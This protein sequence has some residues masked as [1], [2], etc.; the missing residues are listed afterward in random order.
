MEDNFVNYKLGMLIQKSSATLYEGNAFRIT[1]TVTQDEH[2]K[3]RNI[4]VHVNHTNYTMQHRLQYKHK[5]TRS[6]KQLH[7]KTSTQTHARTYMQEHV[8]PVSQII[9]NTI[10]LSNSTNH[11]LASSCEIHQR[12]L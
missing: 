7:I 9:N 10:A 11:D 8:S 3:E 6:F 12:G 2:K 5:H 4:L 1:N